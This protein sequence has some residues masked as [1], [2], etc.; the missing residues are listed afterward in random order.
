[1]KRKKRHTVAEYSA[2]IIRNDRLILSQAITLVES[3]LEEDQELAEE[4]VD[5]ILSHTGN[6]FRIG[7]SGVPGVGKST[8]IDRFG[9]MLINLGH[10]VAI[11]TI[12]PS[13]KKS[14]GSILGDKTRME[15]LSNSP[16][17]FVRPSPS[18][19]FLGG[20]SPKTRECMLLC[21]A[22]GYDTIVV[23]TVGVGQS[24][25]EVKS[26]VDFFLLLALAGAGDG[27]QGIKKG[28]M[29][30]TDLIVINKADGENSIAAE[31][32]KGELIEA[33]HVYAKKENGWRTEVLS[34]SSLLGEGFEKIWNNINDFQ[35]RMKSTG[36]FDQNRSLQQVYWMNEQISLLL[37]RAF[38]ANKKME[39]A[40]T[41]QKI[42]VQSGQKSSL[43]AARELVS[44][45]LQVCLPKV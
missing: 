26:M 30:M 23:E 6:S 19:G 33:L 42:M 5:G 44:K 24:E 43:L 14:K 36:F 10:R 34:C 8:F 35:L 31:K 22:A 37:E 20:V 18:R 45:Y 39:K 40:I 16:F 15:T 11:L 2:G 1:M 21:E 3:T 13:S 29:E 9:Q 41:Q 27:L 17:A 38:Y 25:I 12:D 28:I 7:I 32:A 4:L